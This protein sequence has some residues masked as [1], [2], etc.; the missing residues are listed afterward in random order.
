[1]A[2]KK[3]CDGLLVHGTCVA[4]SGDNGLLKGAL[5]RGAPGSGK[6]DLALRFISHFGGERTSAAGARLVSDDQV[7][8]IREGDTLL[9][10]APGTIAGKLEVRG[11]GIVEMDHHAQAPLAVIVDLVSEDEVP[12]L[13]RDPLPCEDIL[14]VCVPVL[15]LNPFELSSPVKLRVALTGVP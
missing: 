12:R 2:G 7:L 8:L 4:I 11:L 5:L 13:P 1:L 14:G 10:C 15:K 3:P 6:S 9:A